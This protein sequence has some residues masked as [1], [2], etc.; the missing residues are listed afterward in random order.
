MAIVEKIFNINLDTKYAETNRKIMLTEGDTGV[1]FHIVLSD[2]G[3]PVD[4]SGCRVL[5]IFSNSKGTGSQDSAVEGNGVTIG[6]DDYNEITIKLKPSRFA[7][8]YNECEI[9]VYSGDLMGTLITTAR[10]N[11]SATPSILNPDT[12]RED[13]KYPV[14]LDLI[15]QVKDLQR[16]AGDMTKDAYD[17]DRDGK[18]LLADYADRAESAFSA[19]YVGGRDADYFAS[20][21]ALDVEVAA[22][23]ALAKVVGDISLGELGGQPLKAVFTNVHVAAS[24]FADTKNGKAFPFRA[25][26]PLSGVDANTYLDVVYDDEQRMSGIFS[27][28]V[29][30]YN[31]GVYLYAE[32]VP[33]ADFVIPTIVAWR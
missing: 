28:V 30:T 3:N 13:E 20:K 27:G 1:V 10:F 15:Q 9:Q 7:A 32:S 22:R 33:E 24:S 23:E 2:E 8:G 17:P 14:L 12:I 25:S 31:G 11:F 4:L 29:D 21:A 26:V 19:D 16:G 18:V 5:A 6:G